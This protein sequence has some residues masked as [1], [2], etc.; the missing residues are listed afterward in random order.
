[1]GL[2]AVES[3]SKPEI[4]MCWADSKPVLAANATRVSSSIFM[5]WRNK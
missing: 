4:L 2:L 1:M 3:I 5:V